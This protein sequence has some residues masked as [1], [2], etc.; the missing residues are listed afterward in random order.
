M[1]KKQKGARIGFLMGFPFGNMG[2]MNPFASSFFSNQSAGNPFQSPFFTSQAQPAAPP[3][4][5]PQANATQPTA[6]ASSPWQQGLGGL[7]TMYQNAKT[8][9]GYIDQMAPAVKNLGPM[10]KM[11]TGAQA[12]HS[13]RNRVHKLSRQAVYVKKS[14]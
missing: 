13:N 7:G 6:Q 11:F 9:M 10:F 1:S 2:A 4:P 8:F 12:K 14:R 5:A 3:K